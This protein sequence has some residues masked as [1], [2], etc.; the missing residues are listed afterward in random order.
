MENNYVYVT[1]CYIVL[2]SIAGI[3]SFWFGYGIAN[4]ID[5]IRETKK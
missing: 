1:M 5:R 3:L 2:L 4:F